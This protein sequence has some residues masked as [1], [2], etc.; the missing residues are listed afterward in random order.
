ML[1]SVLYPLC[2]CSKEKNPEKG[3]RKM[4]GWFIFVWDKDM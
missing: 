2:A 1:F 3:A 4:V